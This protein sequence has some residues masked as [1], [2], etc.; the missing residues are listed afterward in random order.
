MSSNDIVNKELNE[1]LSMIDDVCRDPKLAVDFYNKVE[2]VISLTGYKRYII[3]IELNKK[4]DIFWYY[5]PTLVIT[6]KREDH[7]KAKLVDTALKR[8]FL[9]IALYRNPSLR[10]QLN[11]EIKSSEIIQKL[12]EHYK[13]MRE[14][15]HVR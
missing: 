8:L 11:R 14:E 5:I 6:Y 9:F 2:K 4:E 10:D 15:Y 13:Q 1:L 12:I 7:E 3:Y